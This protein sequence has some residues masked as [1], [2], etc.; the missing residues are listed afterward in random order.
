M[1]DIERAVLERTPDGDYKFT[2]YG[3][4]L[5]YYHTHLQIFNKLI[6]Q[7]SLSE[8]EKKELKESIKAFMKSHIKQTDHFFHYT[9]DFAGFLQMTQEDLTAHMNKN[10][11]EVLKK[12]QEKLKKQELENISKAKK[13][14]TFTQEIVATLGEIF[15]AGY[16]YTYQDSLLVIEN[17]HTGEITK[18]QGILSAIKEEQEKEEEKKRKLQEQLQRLRE[19]PVDTFAEEVSI[20]KEIVDSFGTIT[21]EPL[22]LKVEIIPI[23]PKVIVE[24]EK[25]EKSLLDDVEDLELDESYSEEQEESEE[26]PQEEEYSEE[27]LS[28]QEESEVVQEEENALG[29]FLDSLE[30]SQ[31]KEPELDEA[32]LFLYKDYQEIAKIIQNFKSKNDVQGYNEW[33]KTASPVAKVFNSIK[34]NLAKESAGYSLN[35]EDFFT[36]METKTGLESGTLKKLK[37]RIEH[38]DKIKIILDKCVQELKKQPQEVIQFLR[39][40]WPKITN[41]FRN[42]PN[43][44]E[45]SSEILEILALAPSESVRKPI[46]KLLTQA[47]ES[48]KRLPF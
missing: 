29:D 43:Y 23:K 22:K 31:E 36:A 44:E 34:T 35:W 16:R 46:E 15:P 24:T 18:P 28:E 32:D 20:L 17:I 2:K 47:I 11:L 33:L 27:D 38:L 21:E 4:F 7:K 1:T 10:F 48:L 12:I 26:E 37:T 13:F 19:R 40:V 45:V 5:S 3:E 41:S 25:K 8:D 14:A 30:S 9:R 6:D 39:D 42:A